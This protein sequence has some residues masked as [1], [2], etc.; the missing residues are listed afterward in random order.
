MSEPQNSGNSPKFGCLWAGL[1]VVLVLALIGYGVC[2][3]MS[4]S[5]R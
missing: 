5:T 4:F 2:S 3:N 1:L